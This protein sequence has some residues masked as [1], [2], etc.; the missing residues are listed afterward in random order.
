MPVG[1]QEFTA[2]FFDES[3]RAWMANK[4]RKG[5]SMVYKCEIKTCM[6]KAVIKGQIESR[7]CAKHKQSKL[8]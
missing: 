2:E 8:E 3:S 4:I 5:A 7:R 6:S 1:N